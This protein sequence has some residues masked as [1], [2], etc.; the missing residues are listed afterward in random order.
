MSLCLAGQAAV[1]KEHQIGYK[2]NFSFQIFESDYKPRGPWWVNAVC[3][4]KEFWNI[5]GL[6]RNETRPEDGSPSFSVITLRTPEPSNL[7]LNSSL[8][9]SD[10]KKIHVHTEGEVWPGMNMFFFLHQEEMAVNYCSSALH[11]LS[12]IDLFFSFIFISW[13]L[14]TLQYCSGF[15]HTLTW[16]SHVNVFMSMNTCHM[17]SPSR[18]PLPLPSPPDPSGSSQC[19]SLEHFF[20]ASNLGWW[21][22][23]LWDWSYINTTLQVQSHEFSETVYYRLTH[24]IILVR[25]GWAC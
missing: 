1:S 15:C 11:C 2:I 5:E 18:S 19:T 14:I 22:I 20:H 23:S 12:R 25:W 7:Y 16:I 24:E 4:G 9:C 3:C 6:C 10:Y 17:C 13:R 21:S 8:F